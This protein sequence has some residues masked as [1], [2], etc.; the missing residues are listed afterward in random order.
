M[1]EN[2]FWSLVGMGVMIYTSISFIGIMVVFHG[3]SYMLKYET[4]YG[5]NKV[6][7]GFNNKLTHPFKCIRRGLGLLYY[8]QSVFYCFIILTFIIQ[9]FLCLYWLYLFRSIIKSMIDPYYGFSDIKGIAYF[10][11][12]ELY[13]LL[14]PTAY[15]DCI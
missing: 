15:D 14:D 10:N 11:I 6:G 1:S 13:W 8:Y 3:D 4:R 7:L 12:F 9:L 5:V 2:L